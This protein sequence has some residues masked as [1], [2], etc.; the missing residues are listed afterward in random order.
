MT[1]PNHK[2]WLSPA[3]VAELFHV[4]PITVRNWANA[5]KLASELTPGGH[6]RFHYKDVLA[7]ADK[8]NR[9]INTTKA[10]RATKILIVDDDEDICELLS[11]LL[12]LHLPNAEYLFAKGGFEAGFIVSSAQPKLIFMD[13]LMPGIK[14]GEACRMIKKNPSTQH[15]PIIGMTGYGSGPDIQ[16]ILAAGAERVL[17]KPFNLTELYPLVD[18]LIGPSRDA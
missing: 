15:I 6:R 13:I 14:G 4:S 7:F 12:S 11:T 10:Q 18:S 3:D 16:Q 5:D 17:R 2:T 9:A 1:I 8:E